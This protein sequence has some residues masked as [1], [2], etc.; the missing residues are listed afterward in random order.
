MVLS[1]LQQQHTFCLMGNCFSESTT[2]SVNANVNTSTTSSVPPRISTDPSVMSSI[3]EEI[4][5]PSSPIRIDTG[6]EG[7]ELKEMKD[8]RAKP[9]LAPTDT[10]EKGQSATKEEKKGKKKS[11][12]AKITDSSWHLLSKEDLTPGG[13]NHDDEKNI[14]LLKK[15][16]FEDV[17]IFTFEGKLIPAKIEL[18]DGDT[19]K[20]C[21]VY[22]G[23]RQKRNL[24]FYGADAPELK[25]KKVLDKNKK[26]SKENQKNR[27]LETKAGYHVLK[28][29]DAWIRSINPHALVWVKFTHE[30]KF[31][32]CMGKL[33]INSGDP[34][35]HVPSGK[36]L[37]VVQWLVNNKYAKP[38]FGKK[39]EPWTNKELE[40]ILAH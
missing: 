26:E 9:K 21:F 18:H 23:D 10:E 38:Y 12:K 32:R 16:K 29:L 24:R 7:V 27:E 39:K 15:D 31:G 8:M 34:A 13:F 37:D 11:K 19:G 22:A 5:P 17:E 30:E 40:Y 28:K 4:S 25:P 2:A 6:E 14:E 20:I 35:Q 1:V 33:F 36:E 3:P